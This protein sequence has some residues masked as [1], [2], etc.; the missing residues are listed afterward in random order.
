MT[1]ETVTAQNDRLVEQ[2]LTAVATAGH[3]LPRHRRDELLGDLREHIAS[4]RSDLAPET[5]A[6]VRT[7]LARL[8]EPATIVA[9]A[10]LGIT[11]PPGP[12]VGSAPVPVRRGTPAWLIALMVLVVVV[13]VACV[14]VMAIGVAALRPGWVEG[15]IPG[16]TS[17]EVPSLSPGVPNPS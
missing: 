3:D 14:G 13:F 4:A 9:E 10:R 12:H 7:I 2:Y 17:V 15:P 11:P 8:G 6:G 5:E 16:P 1:P